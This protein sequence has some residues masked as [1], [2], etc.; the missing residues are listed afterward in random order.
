MSPFALRLIE[1][2][3]GHSGWLSVLALSHPAVLLRARA[4]RALLSA[5]LATALVTLTGAAGALVYPA[6]RSQVKGAIFGASS[7]YGNA[8][9][10]K[11]HLA[12]AAVVLAWVGLA[13][14][15]A[16]CRERSLYLASSR[17]SFVAY[18]SAAMLALV[19]ATLGVAVAAF[20]SF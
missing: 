15:I 8:F 16:E 18:A 3:H 7:A 20:R 9:E 19:S 14:H 1:H 2:V 11:E 10:R 6:Y 13:A 5:S 4:R 17:V 12:I